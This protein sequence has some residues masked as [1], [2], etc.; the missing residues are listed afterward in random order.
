MSSKSFSQSSELAKI[1]VIGECMIELR[2][3]PPN[4]VQGYAG[5]T[6]NTAIY[7]S[8]LLGKRAQVSYMTAIG[9]DP[10]SDGMLAM[11]Q[12]EGID[13]HYVQRSKE[14]NPGLYTI[15]V[16]KTGERSFQYWRSEAAARFM[17]EGENGRQNLASLK[18]F[19]WIYLS[20]ITLAILPADSRALLFAALEQARNAGARIA[21]D[22]NF[23]PLLWP[24][25][26]Q[27][28]TVYDKI[29]KMTDLALLTLDDEQAMRDGENE[30]EVISRCLDCGVK[31]IV[32]KRGAQEC[33]VQTPQ[34]QLLVPANHVEYIA[35]TTAAGD[36]FS[37]AYL[38]A[39]IYG[40]ASDKAGEW[41]H[42]L[43]G[44]VIRHPGAIIG[45]EFMP[46]FE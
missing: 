46:S 22:N 2:G 11:W 25:L 14:R 12:G 4:L 38:A 37:A 39:R 13:C 19:D 32:L 45:K 1:A 9:V 5:D 36:S 27:A 10:F 40:L 42:R 34:T 17:F 20:G 33:I 23:R 18:D 24:N 6:L 3:L 43:A 21:F 16:D 8:R 44:E 30:T 35:D 28:L 41:G 31:E 29:L 26:Q 15:S 7:L